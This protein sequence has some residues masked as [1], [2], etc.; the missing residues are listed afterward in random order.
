M[1][2]AR[3]KAV[4]VSSEEPRHRHPLQVADCSEEEELVLDKREEVHCSAEARR[5]LSNSREEDFLHNRVCNLKLNHPLEMAL[6]YSV[7]SS[8]SL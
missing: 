2:E 5:R 8:L 1:G 6:A 7:V 3:L 4:V